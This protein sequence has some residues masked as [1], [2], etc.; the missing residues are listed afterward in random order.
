MPR[1][2]HN[3]LARIEIT[4]EWCTRCSGWRFAEE[5]VYPDSSSVTGSTRLYLRGLFLPL[6]ETTEDDGRHLLLRALGH[7]QEM[8]AEADLAR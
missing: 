5:A 1:C 7:A 6:E 4:I 8:E 2:S 3:P